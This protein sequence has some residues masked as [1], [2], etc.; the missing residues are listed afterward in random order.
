MIRIYEPTTKITK[1]NSLLKINQDFYKGKAI[2]PFFLFDVE[3][4]LKQDFILFPTHIELIQG[5]EFF[6]IDMCFFTNK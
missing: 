3:I 1:R 4:G 6:S 2:E 5:S